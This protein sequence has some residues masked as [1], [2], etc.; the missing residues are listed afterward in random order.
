MTGSSEPIRDFIADQYS[1]SAIG[2]ILAKKFAVGPP[3]GDKC[4]GQDAELHIGIPLKSVQLGADQMPLSK[5]SVGKTKTWGIV[6]EL[7]N[8]RRGD[9]RTKLTQLQGKPIT[10]KGYFR[11]W[12]EGHG[13]GPFHDSNPHHVLEIH[14]AWGFSGTDVNF[15]RPDLVATMEKYQGFSVKKSEKL[16]NDFSKGVWPRAYK[17]NDTLFVGMLFKQPNF[18]QL[19]VKVTRVKE[20]S[21]GREFTVDVFSNAAMTKELYSGLSVITATGSPI[22]TDLKVGQSKTLLGFFS[23]NLRK[24]IGAAGNADSIQNSRGIKEALEFFVF[25]EAINKAVDKCSKK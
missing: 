25:G 15:M 1:N 23:V 18:F 9:G 19:P 5:P 6:A 12:D 14:P 21:G 20:V 11:F 16:F 2:E 3:H 4:G 17:T 13:Q 24:A 7:P 8:V 10:F 22:D